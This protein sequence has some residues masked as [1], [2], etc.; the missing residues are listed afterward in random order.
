MSGYPIRHERIRLEKSTA[1]HKEQFADD[2]A[3]TASSNW[4]IWRNLGSLWRTS[5]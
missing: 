3:F 5:L 1:N 4:R 2:G